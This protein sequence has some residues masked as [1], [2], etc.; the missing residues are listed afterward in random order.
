MKLSIIAIAITLVV[1]GVQAES[2][3]MKQDSVQVQSQQNSMGHTRLALNKRYDDGNKH[4]DREGDDEDGEEGDSRRQRR[5]HR[6]GS[7]QGRRQGV[8]EPAASKIGPAIDNTALGKPGSVS[9]SNP[10]V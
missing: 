8:V 2:S 6:G 4:G 7:G 9:H 1:A 10:D 5:P 3:N